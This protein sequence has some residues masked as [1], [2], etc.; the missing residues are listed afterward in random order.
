MGIYSVRIAKLFNKKV[1]IDIKK[2]TKRLL[3]F[4]LY[5]YAQGLHNSDGEC[6]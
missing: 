2:D 4:S 1:K 6:N 3:L 5:T